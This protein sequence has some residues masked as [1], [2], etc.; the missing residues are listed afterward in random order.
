M[1]DRIL[2]QPRLGLHFLTGCSRAFG[3]G[4]AI[5]QVGLLCSSHYGR[6]QFMH[7]QATLEDR[8]HDGA[9]RQNIIA[10]ADFAFKAATDAQFRGQNYCAAVDALRALDQRG[11]RV[12]LSFSNESL[13]QQRSRRFRGGRIGTYRPWT[14]RTLFALHC[15]NPAQELACWER[16]G[17]Y[18]DESARFAA[19]GALLHLVQD[20]YSQSHVARVPEGESM[21]PANG[22]FRPRVVCRAPSAYYDYQEQ[23]LPLRNA[24]GRTGSDAHK[25]ADFRPALDPSCRMADRKVDDIITASAAVL[26]YVRRG[27]AAGFRRYLETR[28]FPT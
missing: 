20:S 5:D 4:R 11:L 24:E 22:P 7:A 14:V 18:G 3:S 8:E 21:P 1:L 28:V 19:I 2:S 17:D 9:T 23:N 10:W 13:C 27:D 26:Y 15:P 12:A 25:A 6:L 16:S